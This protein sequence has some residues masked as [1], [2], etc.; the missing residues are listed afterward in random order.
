MSSAAHASVRN[1]FSMASKM[2]EEDTEEVEIG[3][4]GTTVYHK[5]GSKSVRRY[6]TRGSS[7]DISISYEDES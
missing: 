4:Q 3:E 7:K 6:S 1:L 5:A 2:Y